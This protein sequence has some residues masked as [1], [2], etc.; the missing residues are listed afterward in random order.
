MIVKYNQ[1]EPK[2]YQESW[3]EVW[4]A[5]PFKERFFK[6]LLPTND[7]ALLELTKWKEKRFGINYS[8]RV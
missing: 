7:E 6:G 1:T 8:A 2:E 4:I 3:S 5:F